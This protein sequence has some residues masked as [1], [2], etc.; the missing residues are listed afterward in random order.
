[1]IAVGLLL[2]VASTAAINGGYALQH[3]SASLLPPL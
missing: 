1:M 2:A 3:A